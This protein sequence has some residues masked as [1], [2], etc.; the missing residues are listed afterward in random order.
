MWVMSHGPASKIFLCLRTLLRLAISYWSQIVDW[1]LCHGLGSLY[2]RRCNW[3]VLEASALLKSNTT[4]AVCFTDMS[5]SE[6]DKVGKMRMAIFPSTAS[7]DISHAN[8]GTLY[9]NTMITGTGFCSKKAFLLERSSPHWDGFVWKMS[10]GSPESVPLRQG[11][12]WKS[13]PL[14]GVLLYL[15]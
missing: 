6:G 2:L 8:I 11:F 12:P 7:C 5:F 15:H 14:N 3:G 10:F 9:S 4:V 13:V 1:D